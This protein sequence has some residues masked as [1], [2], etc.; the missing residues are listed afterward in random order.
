[1]ET[2]VIKTSSSDQTIDIGKNIGRA[3]NPGDCVAL[4]GDLGV[5]KTT[6][7]KGMA[8]GCGVS[9][10]DLVTS[11]TFIIVNE[12]RGRCDLFHID[13]YR[14]ENYKELLDIGIDDYFGH[15]SV[16]LVEWADRFPK[17]LP[18]QYCQ[19]KIKR[20]SENEREIQITK[21]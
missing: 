10:N 1:M 4:V 13:L 12:Y 3:L 17:V 9:Q 6:L 16:V 21:V 15:D 8:I 20:L 7:I 18:S 2:K 14:I 5:G 11:P 19:I